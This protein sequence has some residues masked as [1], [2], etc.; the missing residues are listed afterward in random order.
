MKENVTKAKIKAFEDK[1]DLS[2]HYKSPDSLILALAANR[3]DKDRV[4]P[5]Y[6]LTVDVLKNHNGIIYA[7][8]KAIFHRFYLIYF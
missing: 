5:A 8:N 4:I 1:I 2:N 7:I 3:T 6:Y